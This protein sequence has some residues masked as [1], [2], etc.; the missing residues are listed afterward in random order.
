[1]TDEVV[2][3][4]RSAS[5]CVADEALT[6]ST[7]WFYS[8]FYEEIFCIILN[9]NAS[10]FKGRQNTFELL[11][12]SDGIKMFQGNKNCLCLRS[13]LYIKNVEKLFDF[14]F[15]ESFL[16]LNNPTEA[17]EIIHSSL[18]K[19][20]SAYSVG[21]GIRKHWLDGNRIW[22]CSNIYMNSS[23][24]EFPVYVS[25]LS[26]QIMNHL[27]LWAYFY[28]DCI[29]RAKELQIHYSDMNRCKQ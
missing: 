3:K 5:P 19:F 22:F 26:A 24:R 9:S 27:S 29:I 21:S 2:Y 7:K 28:S 8:L 6:L 15:S 1:M 13:S 12:R 20:G 4:Q 16:L 23:H 25:I 18:F 10:F 14:S 11:E 17:R